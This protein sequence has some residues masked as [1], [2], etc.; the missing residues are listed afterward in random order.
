MI[1]KLIAFLFMAIAI[2]EALII[3]WAWT[4][5]GELVEKEFECAYN[6]CGEYDTYYIDEVTSVCSCYNNGVLEIEEYV[7]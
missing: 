5:A 3:G 7:R 1:W 2:V 4:Y 6:V